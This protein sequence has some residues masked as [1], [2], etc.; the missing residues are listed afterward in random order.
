MLQCPSEAASLLGFVNTGE[1][2]QPGG[3]FLYKQLLANDLKLRKSNLVVLDITMVTGFKAYCK[4][5]TPAN[6]IS[7][8]IWFVDLDHNARVGDIECLETG[9]QL[10]LAR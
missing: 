7:F 3:R 8:T 1:S 6:S 5:A 9:N 2:L 10:V 4:D